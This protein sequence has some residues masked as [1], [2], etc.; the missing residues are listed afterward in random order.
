MGSSAC[1]DDDVKAEVDELSHRGGRR[2]NTR[3]ARG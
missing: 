1:F 2:G 3:L